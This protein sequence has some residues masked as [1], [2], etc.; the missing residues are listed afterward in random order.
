MAKIQGLRRNG[1]TLTCDLQPFSGLLLF[2]L[3]YIPLL[4]TFST[5]ETKPSSLFLI[6]LSHRLAC[7]L[8]LFIRHPGLGAYEPGAVKLLHR[9]CWYLQTLLLVYEIKSLGEVTDVK[10]GRATNLIDL[11][12]QMPYPKHQD[13]R[14]SKEGY[15]H[16]CQCNNNAN[17]SIRHNRQSVNPQP[18]LS[19]PSSTSSPH[20]QHYSGSPS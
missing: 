2:P 4:T 14:H 15:H 3:S 10:V 9:L 11:V 19:H 6:T 5:N 7:H 13:H 1:R 16:Q 20:R 18:C 17:I 8:Y 12:R